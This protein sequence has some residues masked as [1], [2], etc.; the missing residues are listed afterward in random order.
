MSKSSVGVVRGMTVAVLAGWLCV[1]AAVAVAAGPLPPPPATRTV[2][3]V[4][5]VHGTK[6]PDPYRWLEQTDDQEVLAWVEAQNQYFDGFLK[7]HERAHAQ[8]L[9]ELE[10]AY[11]DSSSETTPS[12]EKEAY[13]F[14]RRDGLQNHAVL[15]VRQGGFD[16]K[17]QVALDPNTFSESGTVAMDWFRPAPDGQLIAYGTS[18]KGSENSTLKIRDLKTGKDLPDTIPYT[19]ACSIAWQDDHRG[20]VYTRYPTPGSVAAGE[21]NYGRAVYYHQIGTD[22]ADDPLL[23]QPASKTDWPNAYRTSDGQWAVVTNERGWV[24]N[25]VY[26]VPL[27]DPTQPRITLIEGADALFRADVWD[28]FI[29]IHTNQE[30]PR[31]R[32][33]R[34]PVK[35]VGKAPWQEII[36]Q[37]KGVIEGFDIVGG[38]LILTL[39]E[40][41]HSRL[42]VHELDG[43]RVGELRLPGIGTVSGVSG[44]PER[45][46][47]FYSFT[48]F[49]YPPANFRLDLTTRKG[50]QYWQK[51]T[52]VDASQYETS[53]EWFKSKDG[54]RVPMFV[55]HRKGL[56]K[57][58]Q[59][60][61]LLYGYGGFNV[62][63]RPGFRESLFP[64]LDR[65]GVY[66]LA[67]IR[68]GDEFGQEW[69]QAGRRD[70]KQ[71]VYDDFIAA[72]EYLCSSKLTSPA[73]LCIEGG[74]NGGLLV[75]A[76]MVQRPDLCGAVVCAV[77]LLDMI[78]YPR[79]RIAQ[80]WTDEY[81]DP[82]V[83]EEFAWLYAYSPYH[84]VQ[85][86]AKYPAVLLTTALHDSRVDPMHAWKMGARLQAA[87]SSDRPVYIYTESEAGHGQGKPLR[88]RLKE[89]ADQ[90]VFILAAL[91]ALGDEAKPAGDK[92]KAKPAEA[93]SVQ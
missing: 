93:A 63:Y 77:P 24:R 34:T 62:G 32:L 44:V 83:A 6:V 61:T 43:K 85:D 50:G 3:V 73:K 31:Y 82:A 41:V 54:T 10:K 46:E 84:H 69:H 5:E 20:F 19:R 40:D 35:Q 8:I 38:Q 72:G 92:A 91:N 90:Y 27:A 13:F 28:D 9:S 25:D 22:P 89:Q 74:S 71:N 58:G 45:P 56:K 48:S 66:A 21:E 23:F 57:N 67:G 88:M 17:E 14:F 39:N 2:D 29:Y 42:W 26:L 75:G 76:V 1:S 4:D 51:P 80:L 53:Q 60:P 68:G 52:Q 87:S 79:F 59:N 65:G 15:Y 86:G 49:T 33:M 7:G 64:F 11:V 55:V 81:G 30:A 37:L 16:Q 18:D 12:I 70:K 47:L 78:R 36:P